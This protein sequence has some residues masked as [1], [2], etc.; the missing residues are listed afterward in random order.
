MLSLLEPKIQPVADEWG[1]VAFGT[2]DAADTVYYKGC[3][4]DK[5]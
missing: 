3:S 4:H 2:Q 1:Q 5:Q